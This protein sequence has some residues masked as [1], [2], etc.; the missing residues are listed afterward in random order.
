MKIRAVTER[1]QTNSRICSVNPV[2]VEKVVLL[3]FRQQDILLDVVQNAVERVLR[4]GR[5]K[6]ERR[7]GTGN[8]HPL[9][10]APVE[11][12][13]RRALVGHECLSSLAVACPEQLLA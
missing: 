4:D 12:R 6:I 10:Y 9:R 8:M 7:P 13:V 1:A 2:N 3:P 11:H 5:E